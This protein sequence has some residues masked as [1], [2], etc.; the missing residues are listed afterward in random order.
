MA[1]WIDHGD[2]LFVEAAKVEIYEV[3]QEVGALEHSLREF[4]FPVN[5]EAEPVGENLL[6][7]LL[8]SRGILES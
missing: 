3:V 4:C 7:L 5:D 2:D 8:G 6:E 1:V